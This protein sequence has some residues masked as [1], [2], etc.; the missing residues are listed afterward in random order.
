M[1]ILLIFL[2]ISTASS[3]QKLTKS[4]NV[5]LISTAITDVV[6]EL[7]VRHDIEFET[8]IMDKVSPHVHDV[9]DGLGKGQVQTTRY[10]MSHYSDYNRRFTVPAVI[11]CRS[12]DQIRSVI[13]N[14]FGSIYY[15][16]NFKFLYYVEEP[17]NL[18][19]IDVRKLDS[20]Y[21]RQSCFSYFIFKYEGKF[22]TKVL[23]GL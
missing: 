11:F 9:I 23:N 13:D 14:Y 17:F 6:N 4:K 18:T 1:R 7:F 10:N 8:F 15:P 21:S 19:K 2:F 3:T 22:N 12:L 5:R 20:H 16:R